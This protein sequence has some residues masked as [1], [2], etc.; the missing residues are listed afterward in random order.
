MYATMFFKNIKL[1]ALKPLK[2][3]M[4]VKILCCSLEKNSTH[5]SPEGTRQQAQHHSLQQKNNER[6]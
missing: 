6:K 4:V 1:M 2:I 3:L 5:K